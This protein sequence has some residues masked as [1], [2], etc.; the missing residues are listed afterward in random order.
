MFIPKGS[1]EH[2]LSVKDHI[3]VGVGAI[4]VH[5]IKPELK[6]ILVRSLLLL[7]KGHPEYRQWILGR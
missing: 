3:E 2:P 4:R 1:L 5:L 7:L 6:P